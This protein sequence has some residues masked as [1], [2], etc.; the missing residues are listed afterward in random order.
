MSTTGN[1]YRSFAEFCPFYLRKHANRT[2][3]RLHFV[4]MCWD[5]VSGR[6]PF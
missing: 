6:I 5:I 4:G 1:M 3:R 2:S